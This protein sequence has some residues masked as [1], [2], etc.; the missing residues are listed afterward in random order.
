[1]PVVKDKNNVIV[2]AGDRATI[3]NG[4]LRPK[5][6]SILIVITRARQSQGAEVH[7]IDK[8]KGLP[9]VVEFCV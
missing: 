6:K 5:K 7:L 9:T 1:L 4:N 2:L 8:I 3:Q